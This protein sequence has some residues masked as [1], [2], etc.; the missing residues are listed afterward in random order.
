MAL[1]AVGPI[2]F[3]QI[4]TELGL[5]ST[6]QISMNDPSF[7][8]TLRDKDSAT[9]ISM[10]QAYGRTGLP[11]N[12]GQSFGGGYYVGDITYSNGNSY[13]LILAPKSTAVVRRWKT[14]ATGPEAFMGSW[15]GI[16]LENIVFYDGFANTQA[17]NSATYPAA[18]YVRSL[19]TGGFT[20]WYLP[21]YW[22]ARK[23]WDNLYRNF[24][25]N[26]RFGVPDS[27]N[28]QDINGA[29]GWWTS[30]EFSSAGI[31][32]WIYATNAAPD[33]VFGEPK[34]G[35]AFGGLSEDC[36]ARGIRRIQI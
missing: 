19:S 8:A 23:I 25:S 36:A 32:A 31:R 34:N 14:T 4:N 21:S 9:P 27:E 17:M 12:P 24:F 30:S 6:S 13:A 5:T 15:S 33:G 16:T 20:D 1:P 2:S 35:A 22:E 26:Q 28:I 11:G 18:Q 7:R 10:S 3:A 29:A